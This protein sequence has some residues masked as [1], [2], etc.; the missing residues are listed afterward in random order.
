MRPVYVLS[1]LAVAA[2]LAG[3]AGAATAAKEAT[4]ARFDATLRLTIT[5]SWHST[6]VTMRDGVRVELRKQGRR[7][8]TLRNA[9]PTRIAVVRTPRAATPVRYVGATIRG[10]AGTVAKRGNS[11]DFVC[12]PRC[13]PA[14]EP[15]VCALPPVR[16]RG[17][18]AR[19]FA[20]RAHVLA[21]RPMRLRA[22]VITS[23]CPP[24]PAEVRREQAG[25][26]DAQGAV[27]EDDFFE[28]SAARLTLEGSFD[29]TT[30]FTG[31][32]SGRVTQRVRWT[33][34]LRRVAG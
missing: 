26:E 32:E 34:F 4:T 10:V 6:A 1:L 24:E 27:D 19:F 33:L 5:R 2:V 18:A 12:N 3:S 9:R 7:T 25:I 21:F 20:R 29:S 14:A 17:L 8:A 30:T 23:S 22:P 28:T 16:V 13:S 15:R 31:P 11:E